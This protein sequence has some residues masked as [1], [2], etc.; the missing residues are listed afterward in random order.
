M[1]NDKIASRRGGSWGM[2]TATCVLFGTMAASGCDDATDLGEPYAP[3]GDASEGALEIEPTPAPEPQPAWCPPKMHR[4]PVTGPH[5]IGFDW[6]SCGASCDV[7]CPDANANSDYDPDKSDGDDHQGIDVFASYRAPLVAVVD[8]TIVKAG[9]VSDTSGIRVRLRDACGWEYYYGHLDEKTVVAGQQVKAGEVVGYMGSTGTASVHLHFNVSA[10]GGY[11]AN[12]GGINPFELLRSTSPTACGGGV[13]PPA[14]PPGPDAEPPPPPPEDPPANPPAPGCGTMQPDDAL[15]EN[16]VLT[17]CDGRFNLVAQAD[18]NLVLYQGNTAL[19]HTQT[20]GQ[21]L[22]A[23]VMQSDGNL[24]L[25]APDGSPLWHIG[26]H[27]NPGARLVL[28]DDGNLVVGTPT[29][30]LWASGSSGT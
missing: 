6:D 20:H 21:K 13:M 24:V 12:N 30:L 2:W 1:T 7:S 25:Y 3:L 11:N 4:F 10:D 15:L 18:G 26:T 27:G 14:P 9:V 28:T 19:W 16:D 22:N 23:L 5:N 29:K 17:S 8:G